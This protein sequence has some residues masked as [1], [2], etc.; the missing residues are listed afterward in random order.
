M[1]ISI[2]YKIILLL[3]VSFG[4]TI[5][6]T[7]AYQHVSIAQ[8][9]EFYAAYQDS[10]QRIFDNY[11]DFNSE[12][13][14][15]LVQDYSVWDEMVNVIKYDD[16]KWA[17]ENLDRTILIY[18]FSAFIIYKPDFSLQYQ[19]RDSVFNNVTIFPSDFSIA[20]VFSNVKNPHF[21]LNTSAGL[22]EVFGASVH[23][24]NDFQK[25]SNP[26]GYVFFIKHWDK[27][28][29]NEIQ[30]HTSIKATI[31]DKSGEQNLKDGVLFYREVK[32]WKN[33]TV[34]HI[35]CSD[36]DKYHIQSGLLLQIS[37]FSS[38]FLSLIT[39]I[40]FFIATRNWITKPLNHI[41]LALRK[42]SAE[43]LK[44]YSNHHSEF[45]DIFIL[46]NDFFV[47]KEKLQAEIHER[48]QFQEALRIS[49][50][51]YK[52]LL[53]LLPDMVF[54]Y[55]NGIIKYANHATIDFIG[56]TS[57]EF[58]NTSFWDWVHPDYKQEI[59][60]NIQKRID[61]QNVPEYE[62]EIITKNN[63][64][65][66]V[67]VR[68]TVVNK[69]SDNEI[70]VVLVDIT[71]RKKFEQKLIENE[72]KYRLL[73][74]I[75][76]DSVILHDKGKIVFSNNSTEL[77]TGFSGD[78]LIQK[79]MYDLFPID[80]R[81][82]IQDSIQKR[83]DTENIAEYEI[84]L[85]RKDTHIRNVLLRS[86]KVLIDNV[87]LSF[88]VLI[89][90]THRKKTETLLKIN[91]ERFRMIADNIKDGLAII[92]NSSMTY[93][94]NQLCTILGIDAEHLNLNNFYN[95]IASFNR[96]ETLRKIT[97][98][99]NSKERFKEI[100]FWIS[101]SNGE[102]RYLVHNY[103]NYIKEDG[104]RA[105]Y[106]VCSDITERKRTE[107]AI[108]ESEKK[109]KGFLE[110]SSD[111]V[112]LTN[113]EGRIIE[114]NKVFE[115]IFGIEKSDII[116]KYSWDLQYEY[117]SD[118]SRNHGLTL[119]MLHAHAMVL[120]K[121][122]RSPF[123]SKALE[124][125]IIRKDQQTRVIE[126]SMFPIPT[127]NGFL[128]GSVIRD[129]SES[130][131]YEE[132]LNSINSCFLAFGSDF[133]KNINQLVALIGEILGANC[134]FYNR[135]ENDMF[136]SIGTWNAPADFIAINI[137]EGK[138]CNDL[139]FD[140]KRE[141]FVV[142]NL[143]SSVFNITD[144]NIEK[145]NFNTYA[146]HVIKI[147]NKS[148]GTLC[149]YFTEDYQPSENHKKLF[150]IIAAAVGIEEERKIAENS[151]KNSEQKFRLLF[152]NMTTGFALHQIIFDA[153]NEPIDYKVIDANRVYEKMMHTNLEQIINIPSRE[154]VSDFDLTEIREQLMQ[155]GLSG[156][157]D[158]IDFFEKTHNKYLNIYAY[159]PIVN[160]FA[161]IIEDE[162]DKK[163]ADDALIKAE[164]RYRNLF[165]NTPL[166]VYRTNP[167]G[168]FI[169][170]NRTFFTLLGCNDFTDIMY[171]N[172]KSF[173]K[174]ID[175]RL[176]FADLLKQN[177]EAIGF[178]TEWVQFDGT[179]IYVRENARGVSDEDGK[180]IFYEGT[181]ENITDYKKA[182]FA[183][184]DSENKFRSLYDASTDAIF[185]YDGKKMIDCNRATSFYFGYSKEEFLKTNLYLISYPKQ[186]N[187][188]DSYLLIED[189]VTETYEN[190]VNIFEWIFVR[191]NN[192]KFYADV[193]LN[194]IVLKDKTLVQA[195]VRDIS[196]RKEMENIIHERFNEIVIKNEH[197]KNQADLLEGKN[198]EL[199][200][201]SIV[202]SYTD[203][204]V[205]II[206]S[207]G[208]IEWVND[209][210]ERLLGLSFFEF[211]KRYGVNF[212]QTSLNPEIND[213]IEECI[214]YKKSATYSTRTINGVGKVIWLQTSL[215]PIFDAD[216]K[217]WKFI[218]IDVDVT[219]LK[220]A[221]QEILVQKEEIEAQRDE[222]EEKNRTM[223]KA[224][225]I[226]EAKNKNITDSI[227]Y[228]KKIQQAIVPPRD[229]VDL[230][231]PESFILFKPKD[232]VSGDFYWLVRKNN[233]LFVSVIDCTGH[234]VP[235]AFM[236]IVAN[237]ILNKAI[238]ENSLRSPAEILNY[239][240]IQLR[241]TFHQESDTGAM[242]KD[243]MD[244]A[245]CALDVNTLKLQFSGAY[246]PLF[247]VR[248]KEL[249]I[250]IPNK[251]PIGMVFNELFSSYT[252]EE[253]Q[254]QKEDAIY[255][256]SDGF[257]DQLGGPFERKFM[258]KRFKELI[259]SHSDL[260]MVVQKQYLL[261]A[262]HQ[263]QGKREQVD[264]ILVMGIRI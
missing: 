98:F 165:N 138:I 246:N 211:S 48:I 235:G 57:E 85:I 16:F 257:A 23:Y 110:S 222:I 83:I 161:V 172:V 231:I 117:T 46:F 250:G 141:L 233:T 142:R 201:L 151:L 162:T 64:K 111:G 82:L 18:N 66:N 198:K 214:K 220:L 127:Q 102:L 253:F 199:E 225:Y 149:A 58:K 129:I 156:K 45:A 68:A 99:A 163:R 131:K 258:N 190:N 147:E 114:S 21:F 160:H 154:V 145:Y 213:V 212:Y 196:E 132:N 174:K 227:R 140:E 155:V 39:I 166:G 209:A 184:Q 182:L 167:E 25:K 187:G 159:S 245:F 153:K 112:I 181:V 81:A 203:N 193:R 224:N 195:T 63:S 180:V 55:V 50:S 65:K 157:P 2:Q 116:G 29:L 218:A 264:D 215:T 4:L 208:T 49:E 236:S 175:D 12:R 185:I 109:Y 56:I 242:I 188:E 103:S 91:E 87:P 237:N 32:N 173:Y 150:G 13:F 115:R 217:I 179:V 106:V 30:I 74:N 248:K 69:E 221:E 243:G 260:P 37:I 84:E 226:I 186:E 232:I 204:I 128:V 75:L 197:I 76:P 223:L 40:I 101:K 169:L 61:G 53:N 73:L 70:L 86:T 262:L 202:A 94:N 130:K 88:M 51:K 79:S 249:I 241:N 158:L 230:L 206:D 35:E 47:Q 36:I 11:I 77:L 252:N 124:S 33:Q 164:E 228:A 96:L 126:S 43:P 10:H 216:G 152:E 234:G 20:D 34:A 189:K 97:D 134:V 72:Q 113:E 59:I 15:Q 207:N 78:E 133:N 17:K 229:M 105:L 24:T 104:S 176:F 44:K 238:N 205:L 263:W 27:N 8:E 3:A 210:F 191:K 93:F 100:E 247:I 22:V 135:L 42:G 239:L 119:E 54:V 136:Y 194:T 121:T 90:Y 1:K 60:Q 240:N 123:S 28:F 9:K 118:I 125:I 170:A 143:Q 19:I 200:K 108:A 31:F 244:L 67:I 71:Q 80:S 144:S 7:I 178:E 261:E 146:G 183:I 171:R 254:L 168:D 148:A 192:E 120:L 52:S 177:G 139:I 122:G 256:F 5:F 26:F 251:F 95:V 219:K 259:V 14:H 137:A 255:L 89:D 41:S 62:I 6:S 92:E 38:A 107:I